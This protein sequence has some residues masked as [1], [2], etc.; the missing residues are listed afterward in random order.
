MLYSTGATAVFRHGK[1]LL[2]QEGSSTVLARR[3]ETS[4]PKEINEAHLRAEFAPSPS[5]G[6]GTRSAA[7]SG[8]ATPVSGDQ[9]PF[10]RPRGPARKR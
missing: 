6:E 9:K 3:I 1:A 8:T 10:A 2:E 7:G 5:A 4:D